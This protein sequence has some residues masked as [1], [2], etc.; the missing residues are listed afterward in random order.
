MMSEKME[1]LPFSAVNDFMRD[2]YRITVM[3]EVFSNLEKLDKAPRTV[4]TT[5]VSHH[6]SV[7]GFR[8]GN[9]A[10]V[11]RKVKASVSLFERAPEFAAAVMQGWSSLHPQ[12][13]T[14]VVE[15]L[16]ELGWE[17][18]LPADADRAQ[19]P[20]FQIHWPKKDNFEAILAQVKAKQPDLEESEDNVSLMAVWMGN[21][22]P[23][24]LY[25]EEEQQSAE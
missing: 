3:T 4:I 6:V 15:V 11:G 12:L 25:S 21:R 13:R 8:N 17:N 9:L 16:T 2:D 24:D 22:L 7:P 14:V 1:Y 19:L 10:P 23:Y 18:V 20:G 5:A